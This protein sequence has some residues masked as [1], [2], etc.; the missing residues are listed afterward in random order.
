MKSREICGGRVDN[1]DPNAPKLIRSKKPVEFETHFWA[2]TRINSYGQEVFDLSVKKKE[3]S[4]ELILSCNGRQDLVTDEAFL[5]EVQRIIEKNSL[6]GLNGKREY[7]NG[8]PPEDQP[9]YMKVLYDSGEMLSFSIP[10][11]PVSDWCNDLRKL[12]FDELVRQGIEDMLPPK[13]DRQVARFDLKIHKWPLNIWYATIRTQD[14]EADKRP[15]HYLRSVWNKETQKSEMSDISKI[16]EGFYENITRLVEETG[17]RD[18]SNGKIDFPMG[19][20]SDEVKEDAIG[21]CAEGISGKQFNTFIY[22][23]EI[24]DGLREAVNVIKEYID[25]VLPKIG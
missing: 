7:V 18:F 6:V 25:S 15:V 10:G 23:D 17:L 20:K 21:Y 8:L 24:Q 3:G 12:L 4:D 14:D 19:V 11:N 2:F 13:E 1:S 9:Y 5:D 22:G 16:P